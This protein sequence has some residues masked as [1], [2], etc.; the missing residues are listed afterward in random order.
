MLNQEYAIEKLEV[1]VV[2]A[3]NCK[4]KLQEDKQSK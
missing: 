3:V 1:E 4:G 2:F